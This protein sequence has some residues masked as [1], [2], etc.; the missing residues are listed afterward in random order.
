MIVENS[1]F[2]NNKARQG[3]VIGS[4]DANITVKGSEFINN[5]NTVSYGGAIRAS[6]KLDVT[7]SIFINNKANRDGGAIY[8]GWRGDATIT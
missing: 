8:I 5:T 4:N 2:Y 3:I 1:K 6:A 7:E